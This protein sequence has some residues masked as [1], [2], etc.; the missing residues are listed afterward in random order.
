[1][2]VVDASALVAVLT[3]GGDIG[4]WAAEQL[5]GFRLAAPHLLPAEVANVLRRA[6]NTGHISAD[7]GVQA[8]A[9]LLRLHFTLYPFAPF[10]ER[11]WELRGATSTYDAWYVALAETLG[12]DLVT[13][14]HRLARTQGPRCTFI[15]PGGCDSAL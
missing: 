2:R 14:D 10:A 15:A 3:D 6:V 4:D 12:A 11:I 5:P 8:Y 9:D 13:L 7:A 1:M